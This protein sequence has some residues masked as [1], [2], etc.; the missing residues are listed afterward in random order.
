[1]LCTNKYCSICIFLCAISL[2]SYPNSSFAD[3]LFK[4]ESYFHASI[5]YEE[6]IFNSGQPGLNNHYRY[7]KALCYKNLNNYTKALNELQQ[8]YLPNH[9]DSLYL[10]VLYQLSFL[11]YVTNEPQKAL[12]KIDEF[13]FTT[14]DSIAFA[15]F[16]PIKALCHNE[17]GEY[18][19]AKKALLEWS[20]YKLSNPAAQT[21]FNG[22]VEDLYY[23]KNLPRLVSPKKAQDLS[24]FIPGA[25]QAYAGH[26]GEGTI[27]FLISLSLLTFSAYQ[28]SNGF[29]TLKIWD[30]FYITGYLAGI[31]MLAKIY[32]GGIKRA[33]HLANENNKKEISDFNHQ[34]N[35]LIIENL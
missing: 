31:G 21:E 11:N 29:S 20:K 15:A 32:Q 17:L 7:Q 18:E 30:G 13:I 2:N 12:W 3:S 27:N 19:Q 28:F 16:L 6:L 1:M 14:C 22:W 34:V 35:E 8:I 5:A 9:A 10:P 33:G 26:I 4:A 24:R 25:G 23:K